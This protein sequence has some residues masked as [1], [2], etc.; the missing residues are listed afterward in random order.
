MTRTPKKRG[1]WRILFYEVRWTDDEQNLQNEFYKKPGDAIRRAN[2]L[3]REGCHA[4]IYRVNG[5]NG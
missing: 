3:R 2:W 5:Y 1:T 4:E